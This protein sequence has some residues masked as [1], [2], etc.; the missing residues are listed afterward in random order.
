MRIQYVREVNVALSCGRL[1]TLGAIA[2]W[3][4]ARFVFGIAQFRGIAT[5]YDV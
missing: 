1:E 2:K 5:S 4:T 3:R